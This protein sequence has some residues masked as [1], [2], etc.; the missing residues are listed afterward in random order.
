MA[1]THLHKAGSPRTP[2]PVC[3]QNTGVPW[4]VITAGGSAITIHLRCSECGHDWSATR[5]ADDIQSDLAA[6]EPEPAIGFSAKVDRR[7]RVR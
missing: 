7:G 1:T 4:A 3:S 6:L 5:M 2:C